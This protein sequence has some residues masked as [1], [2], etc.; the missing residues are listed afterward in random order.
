ME[1]AY[2]TSQISALSLIHD[3]HLRTS[4]ATATAVADEVERVRREEEAQRQGEFESALTDAR[5]ASEK[6]ATEKDAQIAD[7]SS[8]VPPLSLPIPSLTSPPPS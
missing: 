1:T 3:Q 6:L 5:Q 2:T 7:V 8:K 4:E